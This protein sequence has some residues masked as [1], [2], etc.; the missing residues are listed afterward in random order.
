MTDE[1]FKSIFF[2]VILFSIS[3]AVAMGLLR[4]YHWRRR[5]YYE[6]DSSD[7]QKDLS[8]KRRALRQKLRDDPDDDTL[9]EYI[10]LNDKQITEMAETIHELK[11]SEYIASKRHFQEDILRV[12]PLVVVLL[13]IVLILINS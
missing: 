10:E 4:F 13:G 5:V 12:A 9:L 8:E 7:N 2:F 6:K 11:Q 3:M 1:I